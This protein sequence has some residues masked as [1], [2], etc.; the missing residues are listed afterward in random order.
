MGW[1]RRQPCV[2]WWQGL[3]TPSFGKDEGNA[4]SVSPSL[5]QTGQ[6][7]TNV[8][9][10]EALSWCR[11][12]LPSP[13]GPGLVGGSAG[14][15]QR[16]RIEGP[17]H[18]WASGFTLR[19]RRSQAPGPR[20]CGPLARGPRAAGRLNECRDFESGLGGGGTDG[21]ENHPCLKS[22]LKKL[23][24]AL[25]SARCSREQ[26]NHQGSSKHHRQ[27]TRVAREFFS[28]LLGRK[29]RW[30]TWGGPTSRCELASSSIDG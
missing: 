6:R 14:R 9:P 30:G 25:S 15:L 17:S 13:L 27:A 24:V 22:S 7:Q 2:S 19:P 18:G 8:Q 28:T 3:K 29:R 5:R 10:Q 16:A 1:R 21:G 12:T 20:R 26:P 11:S 4:P 23:D